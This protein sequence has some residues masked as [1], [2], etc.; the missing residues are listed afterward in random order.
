[1]IIDFHCHVGEDIDGAKQNLKDLARNMKKLGITKAVIFP[2]KEK[3]D[4]PVLSSI[5]LLKLIEKKKQFIPFLRFNPDRMTPEK[6]QNLIDIGF[7]GVKLHPKSENFDPLK[8]KHIILYKII[9]RNNLPLLIHTKRYHNY[10]TDPERLCK[11]AK[12]VPELNIILAHFADAQPIVFHK[13]AKYPNLYVESS[14]K[15]SSYT[16]KK[17]VENGG[18]H[19]LLFGSDSPYMDTEVELL[20]LKKLDI[21]KEDKDN[22]LFGNAK[23]LLGLK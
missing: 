9:A 13:V 4:G 1:M 11:I 18:S 7:K 22:I 6:L 15:S 2:F 12:M 5:K 8:K 3:E 23:R 14:L 16:I 10:L 17:M 20:K 21:P 19:K